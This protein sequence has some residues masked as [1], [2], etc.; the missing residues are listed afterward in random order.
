MAWQA[1]RLV[2]FGL[3]P[4]R[5]KRRVRRELR[6]GTTVSASAWAAAAAEEE[7]EEEEERSGLNAR[8]LGLRKE[9]STRA[10]EEAEEATVQREVR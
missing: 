3:G 8:S 7:E 10:G 6:S 9:G 1:V 2:P 5:L 4:S